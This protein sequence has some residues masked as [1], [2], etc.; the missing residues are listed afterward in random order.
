MSSRKS[1]L[2]SWHNIG[3][4]H[5]NRHFLTSFTLQG[6]WTCSP[7]MNCMQAAKTADKFLF[8]PWWPWPLNF[9]LVRAMAQTSLLC[10]FGA[11]PFSG[12]PRHL[13]HKQKSTTDWRH[14]KQNLPQFNACGNNVVYYHQRRMKPWPHVTGTKNFMKF[15]CAVFEIRELR[16][17]QTDRLTDRQTYRR[18]H[19]TTWHPYCR[20]SKYGDWIV[21]MYLQHGS[22]VWWRS[23]FDKMIA[24][25]LLSMEQNISGVA[26]ETDV[27]IMTDHFVFQPLKRFHQLSH[28]NTLNTARIPITITYYYYLVL[29]LTDWVVVLCL[30][31]HKTGHFGDVL[32]RQS[33]GLVLK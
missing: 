1:E 21:Q 17:R 25:H 10:E 7:H 32:P 30:T 19:H 33:L 28:T 23:H 18:A 22:Q 3:H 27:M 14:Q 5:Q 9:R 15:R 6:A 13:I 20:Q 11:N 24:E 4:F 16:D 26:G 8:C 31:R 12:S 29:S 2:H